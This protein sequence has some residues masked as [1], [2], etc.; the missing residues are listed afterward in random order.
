MQLKKRTFTENLTEFKQ[1]RKTNFVLT[2]YISRQNNM[3]ENKSFFFGK[4]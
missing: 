4:K 1:K 3:I 2:F